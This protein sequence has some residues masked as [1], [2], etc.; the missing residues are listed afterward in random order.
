[1]NDWQ[2]YV[3]DLLKRRTACGGFSGQPG[4][5]HR[6]DAAAWA[7]L[8]LRALGALAEPGLVLDRLAQ[9]QLRDGRV[10]IDPDYPQAFWPTSETIL[11]WN[12]SAAHATNQARAVDFLL[13]TSGVH[14]RLDKDAV[15]EHDTTIRG[16]PWI[17]K[18]HS[19]VEPT[20]MALLA[21]ECAGQAGHARAEEARRM[22]LNRQL[23]SGGWNY[24]N[25]KVYCVELRPSMESTGLALH[26]LAGH[27]SAK[28]VQKSLDY[29][30]A[31][32]S[33]TRGPLWLGWSVL[34][35]SAWG[36]RPAGVGD[37]IVESLERQPVYGSYDTAWM[38]ALLLAAC[39]ENGLI[40]AVKRGLPV[41]E[42]L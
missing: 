1:M 38:G 29:L 11:A 6:P 24:G 34:A 13:R 9:G 41:K 21:L 15:V 23:E 40:E 39:C 36:R 4:G 28:D 30:E 32:V 12:G 33:G 25:T 2:P 16:W 27:V 8:A 5:R 42:A 22:L 10:P 35:L 3:D 14:Y 20:A 18:T 37:W 17:E 26:A 31:E 19:W 7:V